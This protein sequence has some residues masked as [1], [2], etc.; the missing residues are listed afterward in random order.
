[1][2]RVP[3]GHGG[4]GV[5]SV[6][7]NVVPSLMKRLMH[8]TKDA[9]NDAL[10]NKLAPLYKWL[11]TEPNPIGVKTMMVQLGMSR[12]VFRL[13]Y[14]PCGKAAREEGKKILAAI[15]LEHCPAGE[16]GLQVLDDGD[17]KCLLNGDS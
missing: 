7:S 1:M 9:E 17:F 15:C 11:F 5:I 14:V 12:A 16:K 2:L 4:H 8:G 13:P 6:T 3:P 10:N